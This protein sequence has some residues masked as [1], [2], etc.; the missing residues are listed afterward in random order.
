MAKVVD[1]RFAKTGEYKDVIKTIE[2]KGK[3]PFC[4]DNF[5]YHKEPIL[6]EGK[7]WFITRNS[8]PYK[9]AAHHFIVISRTH[10]EQL[11]KLKPADWAEISSLIDWA[12]KKYKI[13]GGAM[14]MRFG[15]TTFT[16]ATVCHLH[17]HL[18][19]PEIDSKTGTAKTVNFPIG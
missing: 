10:K 7:D 18:I 8:W 2:S 17:A 16:G 5:K 19:V 15:E 3:C 13:T 12:V 4:P 6:K 9:G 11:D 14:A 1:P